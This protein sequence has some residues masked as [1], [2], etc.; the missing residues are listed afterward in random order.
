MLKV[1]AARLPRFPKRVTHYAIR[2][3]LFP[4]SVV[5]SGMQEGIA[6]FGP[7]FVAKKARKDQKQR[8]QRVKEKADV[9]AL[10]SKRHNESA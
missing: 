8:L 7:S 2:Q 3:T 6:G 4:C 10:L 9:G 1:M 5:A